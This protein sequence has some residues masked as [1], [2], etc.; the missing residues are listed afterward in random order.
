MKTL[1]VIFSMVLLAGIPYSVF[2]QVNLRIDQN[3][4]KPPSSVMSEE[5]KAEVIQTTT[6]IL[7]AY[8]QRISM[9][10]PDSKLVTTEM[11][12]RFLELFIPTATL[13]ADFK[14]EV[15]DYMQIRDYCNEVFLKLKLE[16]IQVILNDF[17]L[18]EINYDPD[19][20][21]KVVVDITKTRY[22]YLNA[23]GQL[24]KSS[25]GKRMK[26]TMV[27][28]IRIAS[29]HT[30]LIRSLAQVI[31]G[32]SDRPSE[33][34]IQFVGLSV[35]AGSGS[36][37]YTE[38][39]LFKTTLAGSELSSKNGLNVSAGFEYSTTKLVNAKKSSDKNAQLIVGLRYTIEKVITDLSSF[40]LTPYQ[41]TATDN[42]ASQ[43]YIRRVGPIQGQ[44]KMNL[45]LLEPYIGLGYRLM[46]KRQ[47]KLYLSVK[48]IPRFTLSNSG[49]FEGEGLYDGIILNAINQPTQF[50]FLRDNAVNPGLLQ[51]P[52]GTGPY[53]VGEGPLASEV[54][55]ELKGTMAFQVAP[56]LYLDLT[57]DNPTWGISIGLDITFHPTYLKNDSTFPSHALQY[58]EATL[59]GSL[60]EYYTTKT[61][62]FTYGLRIGLYR[63]RV[64]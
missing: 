35:G 47:S 48:A 32:K 5:K 58:P 37:S 62:A 29:S 56:V 21:F 23:S 59:E 27:I 18:R 24:V 40:S 44:E 49:D 19:G 11:T 50:R 9:R 51:N 41:A 36:L 26:Q 33:R 39:P 57:D 3:L 25:S 64:K 45:G 6:N 54:E 28:D 12:N 20:F 22:N 4:K 17:L 60:L 38:S 10:D 63:K 30:G 53:G 61:S 43:N 46:N 55:S 13:P 15:R 8:A 1:I 31:E 34:D 2:C 42:G 7:S 14:E 16:G 52:L